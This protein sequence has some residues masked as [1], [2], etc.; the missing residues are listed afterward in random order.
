MH[1]LASG[2]RRELAEQH[3]RR[4]PRGQRAAVYVVVG[5]LW[6][7]GC[8][9]LYL[10]QFAAQR[11]PFG[12][13]PHPLQPPLLL[14]HGVSAVASLYLFGWIGAR[15]ALRWWARGLRRM[16]GGALASVLALLIVSG[17][18]LFF[19]SSDAWQRYTAA[20]H[21]VLG[22]AVTLFAIQHWFFGNRRARVRVQKISR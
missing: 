10:D 20:V 18:A 5:V 6:I 11:G 7:S 13:T 9:W 8:V 2:G 22:I 12:S 4:M 21:D 15:H 14:M 17:F 3:R 1:G 16:S 19:L